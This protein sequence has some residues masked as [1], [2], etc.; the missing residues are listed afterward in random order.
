M[1]LAERSLLSHLEIKFYGMVDGL[2]LV[3]GD[4]NDWI[5]D[6]GDKSATAVLNQSAKLF[7]QQG[8]GRGRGKGKGKGK[9]DGKG[10]K[11]GSKGG[12]GS[13]SID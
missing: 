9:G 7:A 6:F 8:Q 2:S 10:G 11:G 1:T 5:S 13:H 12:P 3:D 4:I